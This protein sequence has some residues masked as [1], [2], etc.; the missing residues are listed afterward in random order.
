VLSVVGTG[1]DLAAARSAAYDL[2]SRV[3]LTGSHHRSDIALKAV[4]GDVHI[5]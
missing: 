3:E 1:P 5:P 2:V 4:K